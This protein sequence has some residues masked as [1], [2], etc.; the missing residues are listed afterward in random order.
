MFIKTLKYQAIMEPKV[1]IGCP[2]YKN[3]EYC[4]KEYADAVN[5]LRYDNKDVLVVD[6]SEGDKYLG[7]LKQFQ[8]NAVK[9]P[10]HFDSARDRIVHSRNIIRQKVLDESYDYFLSLEQD[11]IPHATIIEEMFDIISKN[12]QIKIL[13]AVYFNNTIIDNK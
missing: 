2:T 8:L 10:L 9:D 3:K 7:K 4:L 11:I 1:L 12:P 5:N 6:N 13:T